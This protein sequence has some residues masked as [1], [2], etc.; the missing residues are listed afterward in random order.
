MLIF[1]SAAQTTMILS[2][3][4]ISV[5]PLCL[6]VSTGRVPLSIIYLFLSIPIALSTWIRTF[7]SSL[8]TSTSF[9]ESCFFPRVNAGIWSVA[10]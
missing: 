10:P 8:D 4:A 5:S 2:M 3:L 1:V 7:D 6:K 9:C